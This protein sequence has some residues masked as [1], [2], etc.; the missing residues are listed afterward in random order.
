MTLRVIKGAGRL[1][2]STTVGGKGGWLKGLWGRRGLIAGTTSLV[3]PTHF[4]N[5]V[6]PGDSVVVEVMQS[7]YKKEMS[8]LHQRKGGC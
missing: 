2:A 3:V 1:Y 6:Q 5:A 7:L 8:N 4:D